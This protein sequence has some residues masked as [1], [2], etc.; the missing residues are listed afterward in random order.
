MQKGIDYVGI[1]VSYFCHDGKG[2]YLMNKR[3]ANSRDE[4]G[5]WDFGGGGLELGMTAEEQLKTEIGE[6]YCITKFS[7]KFVGYNETF[8]VINDKKVHWVHLHFLVEVLDPSE[9]KNGEPH[10]FDE[11]GWFRLD[12]L[13]SP[14]HSATA[15]DLIQFKDQMPFSS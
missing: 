11:I 5:R 15:A 3:G 4:Q 13:P 8:R 12:A 10:K 14:L 1:S 9:V 6:E 2:N 7:S